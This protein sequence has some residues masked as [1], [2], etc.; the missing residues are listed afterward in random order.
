MLS[1]SFGPGGKF[2]GVCLSDG[3][4][5]TLWVFS[6]KV[7]PDQCLWRKWNKGKEDIEDYL[8]ILKCRC[9]RVCLG[10]PYMGSPIWCFHHTLDLWHLWLIPHDPWL[11]PLTGNL[12]P[13]CKWRERSR[14]TASVCVYHVYSPPAID[15]AGI[16]TIGPGFIITHTWH[17][18]LHAPARHH[19]THLDS[20][21]FL[22]TSPILY[23]TPFWF[24]PQSV[25]FL[26]LCLDAT[27][28]L[29]RFVVLLNVSP[30]P[31]SRLAASPLQNT[32]SQHK[33]QEN[34]TSPR[35]S[36]SRET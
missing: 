11:C 2:E 5:C 27:V 12:W 10:I 15:V 31:A 23:L 26:C 35:R 17:Q 24:F 29:S 34:R 33:Q 14:W 32:D 13:S 22:I 30:A 21:T 18:S 1:L 28:T 7:R 19:D 25:L 6:Q 9:G 20:I 16:L 8:G 36:T 4:T 3:A